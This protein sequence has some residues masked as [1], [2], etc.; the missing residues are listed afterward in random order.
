[1]ENRVAKFTFKNIHLPWKSGY[2]DVLSSGMFSY[3][4]KLKSN[5]PLGTQIKNKAAI[6]FD[7]NEPVITNQ[8]LNTLSANATAID[9]LSVHPDNV[10]LFPNPASN[11]F[12]LSVKSNKTESGLLRV[13]DISGREVSVRNIELQAGDN[14]INE[15]T[16]HLQ[17]GI[18]IVRLETEALQTGKKLLIAK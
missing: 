12:T 6:Y 8:T 1:N 18:Y 4:I 17:N 13:F 15:N 10:F 14:Y 16:A 11:Y 5:L 9:E 3:S 2:G 7:Y